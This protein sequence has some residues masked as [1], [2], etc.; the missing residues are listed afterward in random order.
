[1]ETVQEQIAIADNSESYVPETYVRVPRQTARPT[2]LFPRLMH[3][4]FKGEKPPKR[5][6]RLMRRRKLLAAKLGSK[7]PGG[8]AVQVALV[9]VRVRVRDLRWA[10]RRCGSLLCRWRRGP[11]P[12]SS[13]V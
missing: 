13:A 7:A 5:V 10:A 8:S 9:R 2:G 4:G 6:S 12:G 3:N 1:M 11:N